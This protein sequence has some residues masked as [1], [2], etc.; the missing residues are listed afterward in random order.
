MFVP[1][2]FESLVYGRIS[3]PGKGSYTLR[4]ALDSTSASQSAISPLGWG[5]HTVRGGIDPGDH[6]FRPWFV[7]VIDA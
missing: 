4:M 6:R 7:G 2:V 1:G 3:N 5:F